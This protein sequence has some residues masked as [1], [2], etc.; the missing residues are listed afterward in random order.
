MSVTGKM[1]NAAMDAFYGENRKTWPASQKRAHAIAMR[2]ALE[3]SLAVA[4]DS[5]DGISQIA[6]HL[7]CEHDADSIL[8]I[9]REIQADLEIAKDAAPASAGRWRSG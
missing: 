2:M 5:E 1:V 9:I 8:H 6:I 3:A 7:D 4:P